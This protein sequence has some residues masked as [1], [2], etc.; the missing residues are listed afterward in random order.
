MTGPRTARRPRLAAGR[1]A[2]FGVVAEKMWASRIAWAL[3][4]PWDFPL[5]LRSRRGEG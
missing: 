2:P 1:M 4:A 5:F 3:T